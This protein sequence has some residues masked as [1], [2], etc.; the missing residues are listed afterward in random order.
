MI[1]K[2]ILITME[3]FKRYVIFTVGLFVNSFG[4]SLITRA[5]LGTSPISAIPYVLSLNLPFTLGEFTIFLS[6]FLIILQL[7]ILKRDF[8]AEHFLQIPVSVAFGYFID[9]CMM[10]LRNLNT[11]TYLLQAIYLII[12]CI[13]LGIGVYMEVLANVVM[14]PG[15]SFVRAVVFKWKKD[16]G[17][18]KIIFDVTMALTAAG[19]SLIFA[20]H[21]EGVREGTVV[22][23]LLVGFIARV[24]GRRLTFIRKKLYREEEPAAAESAAG[25]GICILVGR[26]YGSGGHDIGKEIAEKLGF[27][28]YDKEIIQMAAGTTGYKPDYISKNEE[29]MSN[30]ILYD[31]LNQVYV[32]SDENAPRD[33]IFKAESEVIKKI[34]SKGNCVIV[35]RC[36]DYILLDNENCISVFLFAPTAYRVDRIMRTEHM[37]E[38]SA[39]KKI[40]QIDKQRADHYR[41]YT[42]QIWGM[43][44]NYHVCIDTSLG[45]EAIQTILK[46]VVDKK[47]KHI[48]QK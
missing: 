39:R 34:A 18:T 22:A 35:G 43:A 48:K 20:G 17:I 30:S 28:F 13:I 3:K 2:E 11:D 16:F 4:V 31:L 21:I 38:E 42:N 26:Q 5:D 15:E 37:D 12:G 25:G 7:I 8:K 32:F 14:L 24:I 36:A 29:I 47:I 23:A 10:I 27:D 19:L 6:V 45:M 1:R 40:R 41:Y 44:A 9:F 33:N 46:E